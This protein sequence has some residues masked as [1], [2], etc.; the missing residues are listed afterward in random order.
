VALVSFDGHVY[1]NEAKTRD[2]LGSDDSAPHPLESAIEQWFSFATG[3]HTWI[4]VRGATLRGLVSVRARGNSTAWE[5]VTLINA[6]EDDDSVCLSLLD[7]AV[8]GAGREGAEKLFLRVLSDS[9]VL[10]VARR[11]GFTCVTI[12][13]LYTHEGPVAVDAGPLPPLRRRSRA[14][15]YPLFRLYNSAVPESVRRVEAVTFA[16]WL[17]A[18]ERHWLGRRGRQ[19]VMEEDGPI[20]AWVRVAVLPGKDDIGRFDVLAHPQAEGYIDGLVQ[21][22]LSRLSSQGTLL[23][24]VPE[25]QTSVAQRLMRLGFQAGPEYVLLA[26]R[27]TALLR[28][29]APKLAH[30][31]LEP[32]IAGA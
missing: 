19:L 8:E 23:T 2:R 31:G 32:P 25:Y 27:T 3:R 29:E 15:A 5:L 7:R 28:K 16:E 13:R 22:A 30:A 12:E 18:Q 9:Q 17:A 26:R 21:A 10:D 11:S 14:D 6:A 24:L 1:P 20:K 4:S